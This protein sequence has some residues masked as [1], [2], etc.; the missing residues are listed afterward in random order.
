MVVDRLRA[1]APRID[2]G[3]H[4]DFDRPGAQHLGSAPHHL[5]D[6][7]QH[8]RHHRHPRLHRDVERALLEVTEPRRG[9]PG[10]LRRDHQGDPLVAQLRNGRLQR[11]PRL[12]GVAALDE[13]DAGQLEELAEAGHVLGLRL[14]HTGEPTAQQLHQDDRVELGLV[15]EHEHAGSRR[16]QVLAAAHDLNSN[17][18]KR[19]PDVGAHATGDLDHRRARAVQKPRPGARQ[20]CPCKRAVEGACPCQVAQARAAAPRGALEHGPAAAPG[21]GAQAVVGLHRRWPADGGEELDVL[22]AV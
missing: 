13:R 1:P 22:G 4:G 6:V 21:L 9:R 7:A 19:E 18:G 10:A 8:D 5:A 16:P 3:Q 20:R 11:S 17:A 12:P 2:G 15:V 14:G